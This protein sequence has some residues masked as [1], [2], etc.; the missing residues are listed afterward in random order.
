MC[1]VSETFRKVLT[2]KSYKVFNKIKNICDTNYIIQSYVLN[3]YYTVYYFCDVRQG[4]PVFQ[5]TY[6][7]WWSNVRV[8]VGMI[9]SFSVQFR[10]VSFSLDGWGDG[11]QGRLV[12]R[13]VELAGQVHEGLVQGAPVQSWD[14]AQPNLKRLNLV[15][16]SVLASV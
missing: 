1:L 15:S 7:D 10:L 9:K 5:L 2:V 14:L 16:L 8:Q 13:R 4:Y 3:K 6:F 11:G 12:R